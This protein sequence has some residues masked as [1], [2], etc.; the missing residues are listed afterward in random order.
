MSVKLNSARKA[1]KRWRYSELTLDKSSVVRHS[2]N[3]NN[4]SVGS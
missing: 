1:E 4:M 2:S 3:S